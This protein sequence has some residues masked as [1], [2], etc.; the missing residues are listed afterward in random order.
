MTLTF[1]RSLMPAVPAQHVQ[2]IASNVLRTW[3][4]TVGLTIEYVAFHEQGQHGA[5]TFAVVRA[6]EPWPHPVLIRCDGYGRPTRG[7]EHPRPD[8]Q[9]CWQPAAS[10][11]SLRDLGLC[12]QHLPPL[13]TGDWV[14]HPD[15]P[16]YGRV[17]HTEPD[18]T[19]AIDFGGGEITLH[20]TQVP[21]VPA[22]IAAELDRGPLG[23]GVHLADD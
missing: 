14:R 7:C 17:T 23:T 1:E 3:P 20:A 9:P 5:V 16:V 6:K 2:A 10:H 8:G 12:P 4:L 13:T 18:G 21:R 15:Q 19:V 22:H 11:L